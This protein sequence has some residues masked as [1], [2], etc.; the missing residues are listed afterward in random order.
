[1][2]DATCWTLT[3]AY[4]LLSHR[5]NS[6]EP[7]NFGGSEHCGSMR[8]NRYWNDLP[9]H[10]PS[11]P[12]VCGFTDA[13][14][15]NPCQNGGQ[16]LSTPQGARCSCLLGFSGKF[17]QRP[18]AVGVDS[19]GDG[20]LDCAD[21]CPWDPTRAVDVDS[22]GDGTVDCMDVCPHDADK[23]VDVDSD[24]NGILDCNECV[25]SVDDPSRCFLQ[26]KTP[27]TWHDAQAT[28]ASLGGALASIRSQAENDQLWAMM[29]NQA[30]FVAGVEFWVG[31][32]RHDDDVWTWVSDGQPVYAPN[33]FHKWTPGE[34]NADGD[35]AGPWA[36][37]RDT[38][39]GSWNNFFCRSEH[40][41]VCEVPTPGVSN[42]CPAGW[43]A[44]GH[45]CLLVY[46]TKADWH[47]ANLLCAD[48][49]AHLLSE[50]DDDLTIMDFVHTQMVDAAW[51]GAHD[52]TT[53]G[54]YEWVTNSSSLI[55]TTGPPLWAPG[56]PDDVDST[57]QCLALA[58]SG[59]LSD[60]WC[61][62][63]LPFVCELPNHCAV[64]PCQNGGI[65]HG[66][67][68]GAWCVCPSGF[69]GDSCEHACAGLDS[70]GDGVLD[71]TDHC[72]NDARQ[73]VSPDTDGDGTPDCVDVCPVDPADS[74]LDVNSNFV[75]DCNE[76]RDGWTR[77]VLS[78]SWLY[79]VD[80]ISCTR[81]VTALLTHDEAQAN[82]ERQGGH[83]LNQQSPILLLDPASALTG[84]VWVGLESWQGKAVQSDGSQPVLYQPGIATPNGECFTYSHAGAGH[85]DCG[86]KLASICEHPVAQTTRCQDG[87]EKMGDRCVHVEEH[88]TTYGA[89]HR[90]CARQGA[91]VISFSDMPNFVSITFRLAE[92][93]GNDMWVGLRDTQL[94]GTFRFDDG[95]DASWIADNQLWG[96]NQPDN[97][98][99]KEDCG[100]TYRSGINVLLNDIECD[101]TMKPFACSF[102]D[103]CAS[104]DCGVNATG[105]VSMAEGAVCMCKPGHGGRRCERA[106]TP[107]ADADG[108][109]LPDCLDEC[110]LDPAECAALPAD[111]G[112]SQANAVV[113]HGH[114]AAR[115]MRVTCRCRGRP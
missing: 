36:F 86:T 83:L 102:P 115:G 89:A 24:G 51:V 48:N 114:F 67:A 58:P 99:G 53:E 82:C 97:H 17:C 74:L 77:T 87:W 55:S 76:C 35:C 7:S 39:R 106:C 15:S 43:R 54:Q 45:R 29:D 19:D 27:R 75:P 40:Q 71:C 37:E 64:N 78:L 12:F 30:S 73:S 108:D 104:T 101:T 107:G 109:G 61:G 80:V 62:T 3:G 100:H 68:S 112:T 4:G 96:P 34:P 91:H 81:T 90:A 57:R 113:G 70:D 50:W 41:Y 6:G 2:V 105:C 94:E 110:P 85:S 59:G 25:V 1:M 88:A 33:A 10:T 38:N 93:T 13:C 9:C 32:N 20:A 23:T 56:E 72:P 5:R 60:W 47:A 95:T 44:H 92:A 16:C 21:A 103:H 28:C 79:G 42:Q 11:L 66:T 8:D 65:C 111:L 98:Q 14:A 63:S 26:H 31:L 22:D 46:S 84:D 49:R 52:L 69:T 18:C